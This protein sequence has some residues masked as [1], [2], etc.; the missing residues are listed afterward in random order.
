MNCSLSDKHS[1]LNLNLRV[2]KSHKPAQVPRKS[3]NREQNSWKKRVELN[4]K[5]CRHLTDFDVKTGGLTGVE[6]RRAGGDVDFL[7]QL[8]RLGVEEAD[9]GALGESHP[10][11]AAG[12]RHVGHADHRV[13][14][15]FKL[16]RWK[17]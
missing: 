12:A 17:Q 8:Q 4:L 11:A 10:H 13:W 3:R 6:Q 9:G 2:G 14:M 5:N 16:L 7:Q 1:C 15:D